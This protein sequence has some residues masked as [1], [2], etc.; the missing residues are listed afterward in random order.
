MARAST[1][2]LLPLDRWA[3]VLNVEPRH[4]NGVT[5]TVSPTRASCGNVWYQW[6]W[7]ASDRVGREE[8]AEAIAQAEHDVVATLGYYPLPVWVAGEVRHPAR[9]VDGR[10]V[11][12]DL[13]DARGLHQ[14][15]RLAFGHFIG[16]GV[17]AKEALDAAAAVVWSDLDGDHYKETATLSVAT[18]ITDPN[19]VRVYFVGH[20]QEDEWEI[21]PLRRV[22][23]A[24]GTL[25][26][27]IDRHLLVDPDLWEAIAPAAIDG[28][29]DANF[30]ET[31]EVYRVYNDPSQQ[32]QLQWER[33]PGQCGCGSPTCAMCA[34][35]T[36]W[37]CLQARDQEAGRVTYQPGTY[38][39]TTS[40]FTPAALAVSRGPERLRLWYRAG[41]LSA[42]TKRPYV[43]MDPDFERLI[44]ILSLNYLDRDPCAC[45]QVETVIRNWREDLALVPDEG[46]RYQIG[47]NVLDCPWGTTRAAVW[48]WQQC[49]K[50]ALARAVEY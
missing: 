44:T 26:I 15:V 20:D 17:Q 48:A 2:T 34:W 47:R 22:S 32:C 38:E 16:G 45:N 1:P 37:A 23:I 13:G 12:L 3:K 39:A 33:L 14:S 25:T 36:Q 19:E 24:A 40:E 49:Q 18:D 6:A 35:A 50:R 7:Q 42:K 31:V 21:R 8:V 43:E 4:F 30:V 41:Y 10:L 46:G 11:H 5:S 27:E 29:N 28:D 9:P